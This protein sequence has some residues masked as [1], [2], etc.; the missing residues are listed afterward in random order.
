[1]VLHPLDSHSLLSSLCHTHTTL[2]SGETLLN[3]IVISD[4][5]E[6][7]EF[8]IVTEIP[9]PS[10]VPSLDKHSFWSDKYV[11]FEVELTEIPTKM[12]S[13]LSLFVSNKIWISFMIVSK[14]E[15]PS[16]RI[17]NNSKFSN[18]AVNVSVGILMEMEVNPDKYSTLPRN[19]TISSMLIS[20]CVSMEA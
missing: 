12:T 3:I 10:K 14:V 11:T 16:F 9:C 1:M 7:D 15:L 6:F 19:K 5:D 8:R 17:V 2:S 18:A 4:E 13:E 20:D